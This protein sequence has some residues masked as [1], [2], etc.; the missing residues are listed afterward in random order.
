MGGNLNVNK[1]MT[2]VEFSFYNK[3]N[4]LWFS[5]NKISHF[6][7]DIVVILKL[8]TK[9]IVYN[10]MEVNESLL[11]GKNILTGISDMIVFNDN[12]EVDAINFLNNNPDVYISFYDFLYYLYTKKYIICDFIIYKSAIK[13]LRE[14]FEYMKDDFPITN[15]AIS[16]AADPKDILNLLVIEEG[17]KRDKIK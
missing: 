7:N 4:M 14:E 17:E 10:K 11:S 1:V 16:F 15:L 6:E 3:N 2:D 9:Y 12:T 13:T 8:H 5:P